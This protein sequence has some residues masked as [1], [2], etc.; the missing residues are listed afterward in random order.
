MRI[1]RDI[2]QGSE[3]WLKV[4]LGKVT[5]S[6]LADVMSKGR[7]KAPSKTRES[8]MFQLAAEIMTG[9]PVE[10]FKSSAMEW[11]N[12]C[13]P[14]ARAMYEFEYCVDVEQVAFVEVSERFGVSP[15]GLVGSNGLLEIKCPNTTT[16]LKR[17]LGG[18]FDEAYKAQVQGQLLATEREWCDFVSFDPRINGVAQF[19]CVRVNRDDEY[20]KQLS[21]QI[22]IFTNELNELL[23]K[24]K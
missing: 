20:I 22:E 6:K 5:A 15:D 8:Y 1:I 3:E 21:E 16:Q 12:L 23:G 24:L 7:G 13:E 9:A 4:R 18:V 10:T 2:E 14:Q 11:G 19:F 17:Y